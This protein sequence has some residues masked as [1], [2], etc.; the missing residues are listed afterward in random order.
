MP[1]VQKTK[2]TPKDFFLHVGMVVTLYWSAITL[3]T[4]WFEYINRLFPDP[5]QAFI[6]PFS[7][8]IRFAMASLII[9][10]P[11]YIIITRYLNQ[12]IRKHPEKRNL[13]IRKWLI[14]VTLFVA[15]VTIVVDLIVLINAFLG[16]DLTT[17]F[18]LKVFVVFV[19]IGDVFLYYF[20]DLKGKWERERKLSVTIGWVI[21]IIVLA[22]IISGFFIIGSPMTQ[23]D[24]RFD[25]EKVQDLSSIQFQITNFWQE[26]DRLPEDLSELEDPLVGFIVPTDPQTDEEYGYSV[27]SAR[28]FELCATFNQESLEGD[29]NIA[30]FEFGLR[31]ENWAHGVGETCFERTI[32]PDRFPPIKVAPIR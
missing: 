27:I 31:D 14:Y 21:S 15:G 5:L 12:E 24:L 28:T 7:G 8:A 2:M 18:L 13:G 19:V 25:R 11:L 6:D 30:R 4:L 10:F 29:P 17:R 23:R 22:S 1:E 9:I 16:G 20:L 26:K 3:I 32:D